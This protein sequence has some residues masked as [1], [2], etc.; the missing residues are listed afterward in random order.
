MGPHSFKCG[1]KLADGFNGAALFQ[2]RKVQT[3]STATLRPDRLQWG[4]TLSSAESTTTT[5]T[6]RYLLQL[7]WGRTL[8]SAESRFVAEC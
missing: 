2:V 8:S 4:R 7:Q 3:P 6:K 1:K 5:T